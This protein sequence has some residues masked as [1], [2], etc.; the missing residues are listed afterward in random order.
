MRSWQLIGKH[1]I[2]I[3]QDVVYVVI[4]GDI[5]GDEVVTL[6]EELTQVQRQY[7]LVFDILDATAAGGMSAEARRQVGEWY[8]QNHL[9]IEIA[10]FG[11]SLLLRTLFSLMTN[12]LRLLSRNHLLMHFVATEGEAKAWVAERRD[13]KH[14]TAGSR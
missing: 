8:R 9:E 10:V 11:A 1:R 6:C 4:Q 7:G 12:A 14:A 5:Q 2:C 3:E 13:K